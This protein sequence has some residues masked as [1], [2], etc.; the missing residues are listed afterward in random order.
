M[1]RKAL[2]PE[3]KKDKP[4][5]IRTNDSER[6]YF[7][8]LCDE[9]SASMSAVHRAH[10]AAAKKSDTLAFELDQVRGSKTHERNRKR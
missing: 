6:E 1:G 5:F 9:L 7:D 10:W 4:I 3:I 2:P 8:E